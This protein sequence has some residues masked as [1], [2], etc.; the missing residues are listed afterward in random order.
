MRALTPHEIAATEAIAAGFRNGLEKRSLSNMLSENRFALEAQPCR[1]CF[2][3]GVRDNRS[4]EVLAGAEIPTPASFNA[5]AAES[6]SAIGDSLAARIESMEVRVT[7]AGGEAMLRGQRV[8]EE[9]VKGAIATT[10]F[11][12]GLVGELQS[13]DF[14]VGNDSVKVFATDSAIAK[15]GT[16]GLKVVGTIGGELLSDA[17]RRASRHVYAKLDVDE[18]GRLTQTLKVT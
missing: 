18:T 2:S 17:V 6:F 11:A 13:E 3:V 15:L 8:L 5:D 1:N 9:Y 10:S 4:K 7:L 16:E 14:G 12:Q